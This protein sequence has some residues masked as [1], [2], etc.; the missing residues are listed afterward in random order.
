MT[1][2]LPRGVRLDHAPLPRGDDEWE[3]VPLE[4]VEKEEEEA[5]P[6]GAAPAAEPGYL[7]LVFRGQEDFE[8][9]EVLDAWLLAKAR[10]EGRRGRG[11]R[12][13]ARSS[14]EPGAENGA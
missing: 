9:V 8:P 11:G 2:R 4:S 12:R 1:P 7:R 5:A 3:P 6:A 10:T 14:A 13:A